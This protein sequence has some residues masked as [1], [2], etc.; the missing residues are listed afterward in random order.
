MR[1]A[2][3]HPSFAEMGG[4]EVLVRAQA[5]ELSRLGHRVKVVSFALGKLPGSVGSDVELVEL[6]RPFRAP[7][8]PRVFFE[9]ATGVERALRA[10]LADAERV[11]A[12]H[13]PAS[14]LCARAGFAERTIFYCHEP[15]RALHRVA[16]SPRLD[17]FTRGS[18]TDESLAVAAYRRALR[19][20]ARRE[21]VPFGVA[22]FR[23]AEVRAVR[24]LGAV[25]ANSEFTRTLVAAVYGRSDAEIV[26]P[27]VSHAGAEGARRRRADGPLRLLVRSR[28]QPIKNVDAVLRAMKACLDRGLPIELDVVGEGQSRRRLEQIARELGLETEVRFHGFLP[29]REVERVSARAHVFALLPFDEPFGMVFVEAALSGQ[30]VLGPDA[31]GPAEILREGGFLA[32]PEDPYAIADRIGEIFAAAPEELDSHWNRLARDCVDRY[33]ARA[34]R[35]RIDALL[36]RNAAP[37][38]TASPPAFVRPPPAR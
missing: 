3:F 5:L 32:P 12:H 26:P 36:A 22:S 7:A 19:V 13:P 14:E 9:S 8:A 1:I 11:I 27:F 17:A 31:G 21:L 16:V 34:F 15:P 6:R 4:A 29:Q 37:G 23:R 20:D 2:V 18:G 28:L 10:V 30:L 35:E 24:A 33:T 25:W 38:A